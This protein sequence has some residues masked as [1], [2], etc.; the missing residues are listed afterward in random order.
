MPWTTILAIYFIIWWLVLFTV[1]PWGIRSQHEHGDVVPGTDPGA[2]AL[3]GMRIKL[4]WT[5]A[6]A[7][8]IFAA[9]YWAYVNKAIDFENLVTLWGLL[10]PSNPGH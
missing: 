5:T 2:P 1:L 7:S 9:F 10:A 3:T 8:V 6:I 4:V